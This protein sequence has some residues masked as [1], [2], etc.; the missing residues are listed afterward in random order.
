MSTVFLKKV[1]LE[2]QTTKK[3]L[4]RMKSVE[5]KVRRVEIVHLTEII[6]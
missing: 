4:P 5:F 2:K 6:N 3:F 1:V